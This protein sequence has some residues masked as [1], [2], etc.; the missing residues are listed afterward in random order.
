MAGELGRVRGLHVLGDYLVALDQAQSPQVHVFERASG[1]LLR[2]VGP[3]GR[4]RTEFIDPAT[5]I[6]VSNYPPRAWIF[7]YQRQDLVL[8][9]L[10]A[11]PAAE[12][13]EV[14]E[15]NAPGTL[16]SPLWVG[17]HIV[18]NGLFADHS[19]AVLDR[20]GRAIG[21]VA[22][23]PPFPVTAYADSARRWRLN[24]T[25]LAASPDQSRLALAY[26]Y[27]NRLDFFF[28]SGFRYASVAGPRAITVHT[29]AD[30]SRLRFAPTDEIAYVQ[31]A[32]G[33]R[34]VYALFCGCP[35][36][37]DGA[38]RTRIHVFRWDGT[39]VAELQLDRS[40]RAFAVTENDSLLYGAFS[41]DQPRIAEW[42]LPHA[43]WAAD[44]QRADQ[45]KTRGSR[46]SPPHNRHARIR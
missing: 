24:R 41:Q 45:E 22:G 11:Q 46:G 16:V 23:E 17:G 9:A 21:M 18:A 27:V 29:P 19:L 32:A 42:V 30:T 3:H 6:P 39:F 36:N 14:L 33:S 4:G 20:T 12:V 5:V 34:Y 13:L 2:R 25:F 10:D 8:V 15:L 37:S 26:L 40:L 28:P 1:K 35:A 7:D 31:S 38:P 43:E 44:A